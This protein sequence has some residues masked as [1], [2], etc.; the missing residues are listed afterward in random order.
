MDNRVSQVLAFWFGELDASG[1]S[2]PAQHSL[3]FSKS[4]AT[5]HTITERFG[6]LLR[7]AL[8][9]ELDHWAGDRQG[10]VALIVVLDQFSRNI[11]R[12][13]PQAFSGDNKALALA[14]G[15]IASNV[16]RQLPTMHRVFLYLPLEHSEQIQMQERCVALFEQ[17]AA[18]RD[19]D[20]R[21]A[22]YLR[23]AVAHRDVIARFGRFPH[24]NAILG[25]ASTEEEIQHLQT[26]GGF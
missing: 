23:Y 13:S 25:R 20:P 26:H 14:L 21:C 22:D 12:D 5:D 15:A 19:Q 3:W 7:S 11:H 24:R 2:A 8:A 17:L 4:A 1:M 6:H 16:H 18:E 10:L 9:G